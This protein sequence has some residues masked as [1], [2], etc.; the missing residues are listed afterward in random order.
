M[1]NVPS[2]WE[3]LLI[4]LAAGLMPVGLSF[5]VHGA[6]EQSAPE[7]SGGQLTLITVMAL[8]GLLFAWLSRKSGH[9]GLTYFAVAAATPAL[10]VSTISGVQGAICDLEYRKL[11]EQIPSVGDV[12]SR[13]TQKPASWPQLLRGATVFAAEQPEQ[14]EVREFSAPTRT[15]L[16]EFLGVHPTPEYVVQVGNAQDKAG[17]TQLQRDLTQEHEGSSFAF[18]VF[19]SDGRYVV[20]VGDQSA[21]PGAMRLW[22]QAVETGITDAT[23]RKIPR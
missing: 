10:V 13:Q 2:W 8:V 7:F 14:E 18:H 20:T 22:V 12:L 4:G 3:I 6:V 21:L 17:A 11:Q 23:L 15:F 19:R 5:V 1:P 16:Q 9:S